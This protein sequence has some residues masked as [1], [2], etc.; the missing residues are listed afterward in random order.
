MNI[1]IQ[2][3]QRIDKEAN[4]KTYKD[5]HTKRQTEKQIHV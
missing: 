5:K 1:H 2:G 3:E 4:N